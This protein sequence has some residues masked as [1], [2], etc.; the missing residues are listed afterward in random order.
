MCATTILDHRDGE[1]QGG[2]GWDGIIKRVEVEKLAGGQW[3]EGK[4]LPGL[5]KGYTFRKTNFEIGRAAEKSRGRVVLFKPGDRFKAWR[6]RVVG[7]ARG[8]ERKTLT[9]KRKK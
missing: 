4:V 7:R 8:R 1:G 2:Q 3:K 9:G 5:K 6:K